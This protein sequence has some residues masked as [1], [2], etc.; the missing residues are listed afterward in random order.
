MQREA[1][2]MTTESTEAVEEDLK[3]HWSKAAA[4]AGK[5]VMP[6][7]EVGSFTGRGGICWMGGAR[8]VPASRPDSWEGRSWQG[9]STSWRC[10][11]EAEVAEGGAIFRGRPLL[12]LA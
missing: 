1:S 2:S 9:A 6:W 4:H 5:P 7:C 8:A 3:P 12:A 11:C 10:C